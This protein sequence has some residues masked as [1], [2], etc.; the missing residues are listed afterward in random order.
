MEM[1]R[2]GWRVFAGVRSDAAGRRLQSQASSRLASLRL[3]VTDEQEIAAAA[4]LV[5]E[6]VGDRGLAGLVNNAGIVIAGPLEILPLAE[7]R[8][9]FEVNVV[10]QIAVT[11]ALLPLLRAAKG[12]IVN[13]G[14]ANGRFA[15][16]YMGPYAASKHAMEALSDAL[17]LE[18]RTWGIHVSLIEPGSIATPIWDKSLAAADDLQAAASPEAVAMYEADLDALR[19]ATRKLAAGAIPVRKVALAVAHALTAARPKPRYPVGFDTQVAFRLHKW[20]PD[21]LWDQ[22][23][24]KQLGLP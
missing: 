10:G 13:M 20:L 7:L 8:K 22:F 17:R 3:D 21:R 23:I 24:K 5:R 1:D 14:S 12:R 16:P 2:R 15:P 6:T 19:K 11:Q 9:Q 4:V 18:L